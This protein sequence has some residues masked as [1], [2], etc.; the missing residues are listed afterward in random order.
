MILLCDS[1]DGKNIYQTHL[2]QILIKLVQINTTH[3]PN[4]WS[5]SNFKEI[6]QLINGII[7]FF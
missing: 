6:E 7:N 4:K 5:F 3:G 1:E 2:L